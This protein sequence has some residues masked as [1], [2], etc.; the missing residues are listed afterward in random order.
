M[1]V[2]RLVLFFHSIITVF[3][4]AIGLEALKADSRP[5][6]VFVFHSTL[7]LHEA[8]GKLK[9]RDDR[10]LLGTE[11]EKTILAPQTDFYKKLAEQCVTQV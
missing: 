11:K 6:K 9:N 8:P 3:T 1:I 2:S 10:K 4:L 7:P 5:G